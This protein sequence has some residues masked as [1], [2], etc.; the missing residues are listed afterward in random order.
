MAVPGR[1]VWAYKPNQRGG[2][3]GGQEVRGRIVVRG[4]ESL[5]PGEGAWVTPLE[6]DTLWDQPSLNQQRPQNWRG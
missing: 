3:N 4:R 1:A 6:R 5:P 2:P